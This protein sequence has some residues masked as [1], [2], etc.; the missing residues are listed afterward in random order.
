MRGCEEIVGQASQGNRRHLKS[1]IK[2]AKPLI[3]TR[4]SDSSALRRNAAA[5]A[6]AT[7]AHSFWPAPVRRC[8]VFKFES[9]A[10]DGPCTTSRRTP[11]QP[12]EDSRQRPAAYETRTPMGAEQRCGAETPDSRAVV[13]A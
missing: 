9:G 8:S 5:V 12:A 13:R 4:M 1:G 10:D 11:Q 6:Q 7:S 2:I 3:A